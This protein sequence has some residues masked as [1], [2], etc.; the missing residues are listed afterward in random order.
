MVFVLPY[1]VKPVNLLLLAMVNVYRSMAGA[2]NFVFTASMILLAVRFWAEA[3]VYLRIL[4]VAG[5]LLFPLIQPL[6][7][8]ARGRK[9]V[10]RMPEGMEMRIDDRGIEIKAGESKSLV[11]YPELRS[12]TRI[13]GMLILYTRSRQGFILNRESLGDKGREVYAYLSKKA[14]TCP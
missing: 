11:T 3:N 8:Y 13:R 4:N 12:V 5:I 14:G 6:I 2:V 9:I 7:I 10:D 1:R